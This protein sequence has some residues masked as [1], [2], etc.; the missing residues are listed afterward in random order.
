MGEHGED[1][2]RM[3]LGNMGNAM[4]VWALQDSET[5]PKLEARVVVLA[6][7]LGMLEDAEKLYKS[8]GRFNLL[9]KFY[10]A[11]GQWQQVVKTAETH[12]H[13]HLRTTYYSYAKYLEAIGDKSMALVL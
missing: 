7:Q 5:E 10:Q 9:N 3:C 4:A 11:S 2:A 13:I 8:C 12:D 6:L 1:V